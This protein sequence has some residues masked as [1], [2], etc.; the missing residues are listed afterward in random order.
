MP[1]IKLVPLHQNSQD[2]WWR[3]T[4]YDE[5]HGNGVSYEFIVNMLYIYS[6]RC[7]FEDLKIS[8]ES[9]LN[10]INIDDLNK[11]FLITKKENDQYNLEF[12]FGEIPYIV[13]LNIHL[14]L[15]KD[16][17]YVA[18][19]IKKQTYDFDQLKQCVY[20]KLQHFAEQWYAKKE[21][22][23]SLTKENC[24]VYDYKIAR[25]SQSLAHNKF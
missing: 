2:D 21:K 19:N 11:I 12:K 14:Q 15:L 18:P 20:G 23:L 13:K 16:G 22:L 6:D 17:V 1:F 7:N 25:S 5:E 24:S 9:C 10:S 3:K 8:A 4:I